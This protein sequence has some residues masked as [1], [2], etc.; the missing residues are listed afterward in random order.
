MSSF[1]LGTWTNIS[2]FLF[3]DDTLLFCGADLNHLC[4]LQSLFLCFEA[5]SGLKTNLAKSELFPVGNVGNVARLWGCI[6]ALEVP[7]SSSGG[8]L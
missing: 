1:Y 3:A 6:F 7:W 4:N 8:L 2:H 5:A